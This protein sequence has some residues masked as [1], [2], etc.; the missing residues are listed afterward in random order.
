V[1]TFGPTVSVHHVVTSNAEEIDM[2]EHGKSI[3]ITHGI[4]RCAHTNIL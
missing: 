2:C 4:N 3:D 1:T